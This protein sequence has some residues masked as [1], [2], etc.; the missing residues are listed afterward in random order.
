MQPQGRITLRYKCYALLMT[1]KARAYGGSSLSDRWSEGAV[2][3]DVRVAAV[4]AAFPE[5][6]MC[7]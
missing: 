5:R 4:A 7:G 1:T 2:L 3:L 6:V